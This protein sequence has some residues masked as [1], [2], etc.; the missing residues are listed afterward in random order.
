MHGR[1]SRPRTARSKA[2]ARDYTWHTKIK[3]S[4]PPPTHKAT[5]STA[6]RITPQ[7]LT[8]IVC[9]A[10]STA[11]TLELSACRKRASSTSSKE[12]LP[13]AATWAWQSTNSTQRLTKLT[14]KSGIWISFSVSQRS[15]KL[16]WTRSALR[17]STSS[18]PL[19]N[20][21]ICQESTHEC[22]SLCKSLNFS[23]SSRKSW[24][25]WSR[26]SF[27]MSHLSAC[28][29]PASPFSTPL[30][31]FWAWLQPRILTRCTLMTET[32]FK[33]CKAMQSRACS[34]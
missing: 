6:P 17:W 22:P 25:P 31:S 1:V 33:L 32:T 29:S 12:W 24:R 16:M 4:T 9:V 2:R 30:R 20:S 21:A 19:G 8:L 23:R 14:A 34:V 18:K 5:S 26:W 13:S 28:L 27:G 15:L 3:P 7:W 10:S 11:M